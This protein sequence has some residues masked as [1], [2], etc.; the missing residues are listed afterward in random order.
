MNKLAILRCYPYL[1]PV[2]GGME[3]H[4]AQLSHR[5]MLQGHEVTLA[6]H[7][8]EPLSVCDLQIVPTVPLRRLRPQVL[9]DLIFYVKLGW[10]LWRRST[11]T[12]VLHVHGDWSAFLLASSLCRVRSDGIRV[13]SVHGPLRTGRMWAA[14]YRWILRRYDVIYCTGY[15]EYL[16]L[17]RCGLQR[18][19]WQNSG[20]RDEF[21]APNQSGEKTYNVIAVGSLVAVK[22]FDLLLNV[23]KACPQLSFAIAGDGPLWQPLQARCITEGIRN[24]HWLGRL[25][26]DAL[27]EAL[28]Q[29]GIF[30]STSHHEGTPTA[31]LEAMARGLPVIMTPSNDYS[32]LLVSGRNGYLCEA[33]AEAIG[34]VLIQLDQDHALRKRMGEYNQVLSQSHQWDKVA[35]RITGWMQAALLDQV[36]AQ[37]QDDVS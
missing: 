30:L 35:L 1:P 11:R 27:V 29:S 31:M 18:V 37:K 12:Q 16:G 19:H 24:I 4:I 13:A 34:L 15:A 7:E 25:S 33:S 14:V 3:N 32:A 22:N 28:D 10:M 20:I 23:A 8:G 17:R 5:Q 36:S 2:G 9:R 6:Y 26:T 21:F